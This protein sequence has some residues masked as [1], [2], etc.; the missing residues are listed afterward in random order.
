MIQALRN[1]E[2]ECTERRDIKPDKMLRSIGTTF[3]T[4]NE[5]VGSTEIPHWAWWRVKGYMRSFR[6]RNG[7][8][9]LYERMEEIEGIDD[10][11]R[12]KE[13]LMLINM[14]RNNP[15]GP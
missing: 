14:L 4:W 5:C 8:A 1:A 6:G 2:R 15:K 12:P 10:I 3:K 7:N 11:K 13:A 9:I